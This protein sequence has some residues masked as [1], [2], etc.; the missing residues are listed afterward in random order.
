MIPYSISTVAALMAVV[1]TGVAGT[2]YLRQGGPPAL[3]FR[4]PVVEGLSP[5]DLA[6]LVAPE[7]PPKT[8]PEQKSVPPDE[9]A[10]SAL[11]ATLEASK[12][13]D[14]E[15]VME[16]S[17][18]PAA[19]TDS[20]SIDKAFPLSLELPVSGQSLLLPQ[21]VL[22][23]FSAGHN[24]DDSVRVLTP[25][26][27]VPPQAPSSPRSQATFSLLQGG[28]S[29]PTASPVDAKAETAAESNADSGSPDS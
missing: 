10:K 26:S 29:N 14:P 25:V 4:A 3:R 1:L 15:T 16:K 9:T 5:A 19:T 2:G 21:M 8:H 24:K 7:D 27:F 18:T 23:F 11:D 17:D 6:S 20:D 22:D 13:V 28:T 12:Q